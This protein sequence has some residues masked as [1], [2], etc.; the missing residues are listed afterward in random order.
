M[1]ETG[2]G[3]HVIRWEMIF[4]NL[5][6][7]GAAVAVDAVVAVVEARVAGAVDPLRAAVV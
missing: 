3:V 5:V 6:V 7:C 2:L 4:G 1:L